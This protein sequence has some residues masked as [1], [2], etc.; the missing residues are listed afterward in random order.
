[1]FADHKLKGDLVREPIESTE[2][3]PTECI[4]LPDDD[5]YAGTCRGKV[6]QRVRLEGGWVEV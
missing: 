3:E 6:V 4:N 1:M 2:S 5:A